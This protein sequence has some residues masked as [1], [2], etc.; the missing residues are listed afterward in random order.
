[1]EHLNS[2]TETICFIPDNFEIYFRANL[3]ISHPRFETGI[4]SS[5][6]VTKYFLER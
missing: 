6:G 5:L 2:K 4:R 1:M 3:L